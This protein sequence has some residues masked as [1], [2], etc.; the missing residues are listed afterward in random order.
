VLPLACPLPLDR[1]PAVTL[2]H[3]G[4]GRLMQRL[5]GDLFRRAFDDP[6]LARAHDGATF[7]LAGRVAFTTDTFVV[8]P[9]F[10]PGGDIGRLAVFGTVN[11]LAMCGARPAYLSAAFVLEEGLAM[12]RLWR[13]VRSM[14][15][16][17]DEAG[18]RIV[19][20]DTKVV[21]RGKGDEIFINTA[22]IGTC[23]AGVD[24]H[25]ARVRPGDVVL[26]SG[27]VGRHGM[28]VMAEREGLAFETAIASDLAPLAGLVADLLASGTDVHCLRDPTRG[29]LAAALHEIAVAA[30]VRVD[31]EEPA[32]PV[33]DDVAGACEVLGLDP[34]HV[35][36]EGRLVACVAA[37]DA[38]RALAALAAHPL[39]AGA[40]RIGAVAASP[41]PML[42]VRGALG[43]T[44]IVELPA[45]DQLP[46]I[47]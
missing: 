4:G 25:P 10:F 20:G 14:R 5:I 47:C 31:L 15:A 3:G 23:P 11:D 38:A 22:G 28:A 37:A 24:P 42:T 6:L 2:A 46:R 44:R 32:I 9:L 35:A 45:G 34:L 33:A 41:T 17:A 21:E 30:G 12:E 18:V 40:A 39:G 36:C 7:E 26:V 19:T 8:R 1:Y 16:A 13:V 27:D 43:T 29:G